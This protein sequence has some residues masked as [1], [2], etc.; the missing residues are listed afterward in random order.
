MMEV[1]IEL[2]NKKLHIFNQYATSWRD[3]DLV[4]KVSIF[5]IYCNLHE[6][7]PSTFDEVIPSCPYRPWELRASHGSQKSPMNDLTVPTE[8]GKIKKNMNYACGIG[9]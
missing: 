2:K 9:N 1:K 6:Q 5:P 3:L 8:L 4:E 7:N